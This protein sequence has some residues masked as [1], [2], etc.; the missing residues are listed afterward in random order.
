VIDPALTDDSTTSAVVE[1]RC[2]TDALGLCSLS[3]V[4]LGTYWV[5][6]TLTP[7]N[8]DTAADQA[9]EVTTVGTAVSLTFVDPRQP[10]TIN[11]NKQDD[12]GNPVSG[13]IFTLYHNVPLLTAPRT[14]AD[15]GVD[16]DSSTTLI[17]ATTCT[18]GADGNC[19][20]EN[21]PLGEYWVVETTPAGYSA[22]PDQPAHLL[23]GGGHEDLTFVNAR[24]FKVIV[25]VCQESTHTLYPSNVQF[26]NGT[27]PPLTTNN[28][29]GSPGTLTNAQLCELGGATH[30]GGTGQHQAVITIP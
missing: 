27:T 7:A 4:Q 3:N 5:R 14:S 16:S 29:L 8:H 25:L 13:V 23:T 15:L 12:A 18:T 21:V 22:S 2:T 17:D 30:T 6:E 19:S 11:V 26:D 9:V 24:Q 20:F 28:S 10:G 1:G